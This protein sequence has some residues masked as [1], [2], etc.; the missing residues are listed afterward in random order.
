MGQ[1]GPH[2]LWYASRD[3]LQSGPFL[4]HE[5]Q[6]R[7]QSGAVAGHDLVWCAEEND[8]RPAADVLANYATPSNS[9]L[10]PRR[11]NHRLTAPEGKMTTVN[12]GAGGAPEMT[13]S[14]TLPQ[15]VPRA[16]N[17][18]FAP[19]T[20]Q[21]EALPGAIRRARPIKGAAIVLFL[22]GIFLPVLLPVFWW[23]AWRSFRAGAT[24]ASHRQG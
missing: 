5:L 16:Q 7:F 1:A 17:A 8:W 2:S 10:P 3:G 11:E 6:D 23:L 13:P 4:M 22:L 19:V 20:R 18:A 9:T 24:A 21:P 12:F 14:I 15:T